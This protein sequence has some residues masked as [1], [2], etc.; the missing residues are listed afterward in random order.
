MKAAVEQWLRGYAM[1]GRGN[2]LDAYE[3]GLGRLGM[4]IEKVRAPDVERMRDELLSAG[5]APSA[6]NFTVTAVKRVTWF[7]WK[8]NRVSMP[9][10]AWLEIDEV[11]LAEV[12]HV[13]R[14]PVKDSHFAAIV[15]S[16]ETMPSPRREKVLAI[17]ALSHECNM[18]RGDLRKMKLNHYNR[19]D[20]VLTV[21]GQRIVPM[22][23]HVLATLNVWLALR[24]NIATPFVFVP[25]PKGGR[26]VSKE[27]SGQAFNDTLSDLCKLAGLP[28]ISFGQL[29]RSA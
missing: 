22:S 27:M 6:V 9:G 10:D 26:I 18:S 7:C 8:E 5:Y 15:A 28:K 19:L 4:D 2:A 11:L 29:R 17:V 3:R 23:K 1:G 20:K 14:L 13:A 21:R 24:G 12:K 16:A 25:T